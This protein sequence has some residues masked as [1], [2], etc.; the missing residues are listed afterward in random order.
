MTKRLG[1]AVVAALMMGGCSTSGILT[2][3]EPQSTLY[4]LRHAQAVENTS[5]Q[6]AK[7]VEIARPHVPPGFETDRIALYTANGQKIDYFAA[8]KWSE[9]LDEVLQ[10]YT[11]RSVVAN[12]PYVVAVTPDQSIVADYRLQIKINDLQP[13]YGESISAAPVL[14]AA[15]EFT[16]IH[17]PDERIVSSFTLSKEADS[18]SN[19]LDVIVAGME[20]LLQE[21]YGRAFDKMDEHIAARKRD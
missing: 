9:I 1:L 7:I 5:N 2:S 17:L 4:T 18:S 15:I 12:L 8:A 14:K 13:V 16:L 21:L 11:R 19:N 6:M 10:D 3:T 20:S